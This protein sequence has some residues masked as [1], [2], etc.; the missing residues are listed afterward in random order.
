MSTGGILIKIEAIS[1]S[2]GAHRVIDDMSLEFGPGI[3]VLMGHNGSGKSTLLKICA[4][5]ERPSQ[6]AVRFMEHGG[7]I[8]H[9]K[10]LMR[11]ITM[12]F[13]KGGIFNSTVC[14]NA[15]YGLRLRG[16][17][18]TE[19]RDRTHAALDRVGLLAKIRQNALSLSSGESQRLALARAMAIAPEVLIL[20]EPTASVDEANTAIIEGL[21]SQLGRPGG[22]LIIMATHD[23]EQAT[24]L[25]G[26]VI[27]ISRGG[28]VG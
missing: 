4:L 10:Y 24:R 22:P 5:L 11:R 13:S 17:Q 6:G 9:D 18:G 25:G 3:T 20:D 12:V 14:A 2:Y 8:A 7:E 23:R 1:L 15:A 27:T 21:I 28:L 19:L 16:I 26:R